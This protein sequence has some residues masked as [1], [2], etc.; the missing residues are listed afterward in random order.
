MLGQRKVPVTLP[1]GQPGEGVEVQVEESNERWSWHYLAGWHCHAR[2]VYDGIGL[3]GVDG[4]FDC[5]RKPTLSCEYVALSL[6]SISVPD[7]YRKKV[8]YALR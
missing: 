2:E 8:Q 4:Q 7:E 3:S 1:T 5:S 6:R